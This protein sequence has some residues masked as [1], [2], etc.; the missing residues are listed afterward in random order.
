[1]KKSY[2]E[3]LD[4]ILLAQTVKKEEQPIF[5]RN[6]RLRTNQM[7]DNQAKVL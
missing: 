3:H 5:E 6:I 4:F 7:A 2:G 1:M